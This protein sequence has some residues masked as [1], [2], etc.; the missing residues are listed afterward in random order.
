MDIFRT[1]QS[2][3]DVDRISHIL[4]LLVKFQLGQ[5]ADRIRIGEKLPIRFAA[6]ARPEMAYMSPQERLRL[7]F[8][9]L[10]PTFVKFGQLLSTRGDIVGAD[11][12]A[13]LSK[14]QDRMRPF[15]TSQ[16]REIIVKELG[17]PIKELFTSFQEEPIASASMCQIHKATL[18]NGAK[19]VVKV[20]RPKIEETI[21]ED[22]RIMHYLATLIDRHIPESKQY[23]PIYLVNEFDRSIM[24][25]LDFIRESRN[26]IRL[27]NNFESD[28]SVYVP[29]VYEDMCTQRVM[30]MEELKGVKLSEIIGTRIKRYDNKLIARRCAKMFFKMVLV[31]GFYHGDMH[32]GNIM[33]LE[34]NSIGLL[35]FGRVGTVDKEMAERLLRLALFA[36]E[37][38]VNGLVAHM[39]R[40]GMI[41]ETADLDSFKADVTDVLDTYY[42]MRVVD[43]KMGQMLSD[44]LAVLGKYEFNRPREM[45][46]L[47]RALL[48]LE[49]VGTELDPSFNIAEE[50]EPYAKKLLPSSWGTQNL[51]DILKDDLLDFE[52]IARTL[53]AS[54]RKFLGKMEEGKLK[55]ELAHRDLE[56]FSADLDRISDKLS[57][58]MIISALIVGSSVVVSASKL[59]SVVGFIASA[60]LGVWLAG[61]ILLE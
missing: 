61:K 60:V 38:N 20:Q 37:N 11:Y 19:V 56:V 24:K 9:E 30:V 17:K 5:F 27:K 39:V 10:G 35:D 34:H 33:I 28:K 47:V 12:A 18:K 45:A 46:E 55:I 22:L 57:L 50:F 42:T 59:L 6:K 31:D 13:E 32:P 14:L 36:V 21:K 1:S 51:G 43:V 4:D 44:L 23:D 15:P 49:G 40:T 48:I 3:Q 8:E 7:M 54:I 41:G 25:E 2:R 16:A 58:A 26:T 53:P 29:A 52:Y